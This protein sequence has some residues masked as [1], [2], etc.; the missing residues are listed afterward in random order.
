MGILREENSKL[1]FNYSP[2]FISSTLEPSPIQLPVNKNTYVY[3]QRF[4]TYQYGL[5]GL[6]ADSLPDKFGNDLLRLYLER[7]EMSIDFLS[8]L[9]RLAYVGKRGMGA[10]TYEPEILHDSLKSVFDL[11]RLMEISLMTEE[12]HQKEKLS[13]N[14]IQTLEDTVK[15]NSSIGG[16]RAKL[17]ISRNKKIIRSTLAQP[18]AGFNY[19]ILKILNKKHKETH[20]DGKIEFIYY[21]LATESKINMM[22]CELVSFNGLH[23]FTTQRFDK[24]A[25]G[26]QKHIQ[27]MAALENADFNTRIFSLEHIIKN[28]MKNV[29]V[30]NDRNQ[31]EEMF[32]RMLF[33]IVSANRDDHSKNTSLML[34]KEGIWCLSPAYDIT[35]AYAPTH[36]TSINNKIRNITRADIQTAGNNLD[37][38]KPL[39]M[40]EHIQDTF[41]NFKKYANEL[42]VSEKKMKEVLITTNTIKNRLHSQ[43]YRMGF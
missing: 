21:K 36:T 24:S 20:D 26:E 34:N 40:L 27:S 7:K 13:L 10:I 31:T 11:Q 9:Q 18:E 19:E 28:I 2:S 23:H 6:F 37:I 38:D 22:P 41:V 39:Q 8:P 25:A 43:G 35:F 4:G 32:R 16:R 42:D 5:P 12:Q 29:I 15:I 30:P 17:L 14:D 3:Q 1:I 33:N